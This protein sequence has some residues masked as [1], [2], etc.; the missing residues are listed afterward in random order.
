VVSPPYSP[1]FVQLFLCMVESDEITGSLNKD[2]SEMQDTVGEFI[3][4]FF[5]ECLYEKSISF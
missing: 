3:G 2:P 5:C 4:K 1:E